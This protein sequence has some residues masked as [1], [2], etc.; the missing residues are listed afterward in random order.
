M[1]KN[2]KKKNM[3]KQISSPYKNQLETMIINT[4]KELI[5]DIKV[6]ES[7]KSTTLNTIITENTPEQVIALLQQKNSLLCLS[8]PKESLEKD[9]SGRKY[10][11]VLSLF[12]PDL[13]P[14]ERTVTNENTTHLTSDE[15][16][17]KQ[18]S[19]ILGIEDLENNDLLKLAQSMCKDLNIT[20]NSLSS[21]AD[22][23]T[24][25]PTIQNYF[26]EK[27]EKGELNINQLQG[28]ATSML[29]KIEEFKNTLPE[30]TNSE[31]DLILQSLPSFPM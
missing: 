22:L 10:L 16:T 30:N 13:K 29:S 5:E 31:L 24:M 6:T 3:K 19:S 20:E 18:V 14:V 9:V 11:D 12:Q 21:P 28:Q 7:E 26:N 17:M 15:D 2:I 4:I 23:F 8:I 27:V 1:P 25:I